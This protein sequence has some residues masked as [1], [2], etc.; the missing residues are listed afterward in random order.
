MSRTGKHPL[1][2]GTVVTSLGTLASRSLGLLRERATSSLF[3]LAGH[4]GIADTFLFAFRIPN[5]F[6]QLF[7]EGALTASFL[8]VLAG[9]LENDPQVARQLSSVVVSLL[10]LLLTIV[11]AVGE[12]VFGVLWWF[13]GNSPSIELLVGLSAVM[14]PYVVLI[15]VAAQLSTMLYAAH[16]FS[17]P[18]LAPTMLNIV[19]LIA[20]GIGYEC[21]PG[22]QVAQAYL[23]AVGV[24]LSGVVQVAVHVPTLRRLGYRFDFNWSAARDGVVQVA[25]NM[26]PTFVG[27]AILQINT[28]INSTIAWG[29]STPK[30]GPQTIA[31]LGGCVQYP[32]EQGAVASLYFSDR[33]C[34]FALGI[35]GLPVAVAIF[36]LLCQHANRED[37]RQ[38][39]IDMTLGLRLVCLLSI[40]ASVGLVLLAQPITRL[41]FQ[42][43]NF[44]A[45]D[46]VRVARVIDYYAAGVWANCAWPVLV[47]GF[48]ALNDYRT[49]VRVGVWVVGLNLVLNLT[50]IWP[51]A[52]VGLAI[53]TTVATIVQ[54]SILAVLF[55]R[56]RASLD[57][58][59]LF[60]TVVRTIL[61]AAAMAGVVH[62]VLARMPGGSGVVSQLIQVGVPVILG[63]A[64]YCGAYLLLGGRELGMLWSGR[65]DE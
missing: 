45:E 64:V 7:G 5:L 43:G 11:V 47:R 23:L 40:P 53:S 52:E 18:A 37:H 6:R 9:Q 58:K 36:P 15:C 38:L 44:T 17:V 4:G 28:L 41:L 32:M 24:I 61:A 33:V 60:T 3:G 16:H 30:D 49:P 65:A 29:L 13:W 27:L 19:W 46:T 20:A 25:R 10:A 14:L 39:G 54:L 1:I 26:T 51:L 12:L 50:L 31:W 2:A 63:V 34:D 62:D 55:S 56:R 8:P 22:N 59:K 57:W 21:F 48:Y 42:T 35:V